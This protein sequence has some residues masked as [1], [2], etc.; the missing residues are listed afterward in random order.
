MKKIVLVFA[1]F[2]LGQMTF[3]QA[4]EGNGD[5]KV[6]VGFNGWGNG[7]GITATYDY[8]ISKL[9]SVGAGANFYFSGYKDEYGGIEGGIVLRKFEQLEK[10]CNHPR[11]NMPLSIEYRSFVFNGKIIST[12]PYWEYGEDKIDPPLDFIQNIA[13]RVF[14]VTK[15]SLF[16]VDC[17]LKKD[18][19]WICIEVG[20]G[21]VSALPDRA[22]KKEF[23]SNLLKE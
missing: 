1:M 18:G 6:Q 3:A 21:Q 22:N 14:I 10:L 17:V 13:D 5:Q 7:S 4:W 11:S 8:G 9:I 19:S 12:S 15:S 2:F 16:T 20:D 23:Y